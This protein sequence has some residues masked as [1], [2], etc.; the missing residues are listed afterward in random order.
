MRAMKASQGR[1]GKGGGGQ[2]TGVPVAPQC[3]SLLTPKGHKPPVGTMWCKQRQILG[4]GG[5]KHQGQRPRLLIT[6]TTGNGTAPGALWCAPNSG[7]ASWTLSTL[8]TG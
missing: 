8:S 3:L 6:I 5:A 2:N 7:K 4:R 1:K